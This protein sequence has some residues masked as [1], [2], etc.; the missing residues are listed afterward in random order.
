MSRKSY[1]NTRVI[2]I[3]VV[4]LALA[5]AFYRIGLPFAQHES[6][7]TNS[8]ANLNDELIYRWDNAK[9]SNYNAKFEM[10]MESRDFNTIADSLGFLSEY[11]EKYRGSILSKYEFMI[12]VP[13]SETKE[14]NSRVRSLAN[15]IK[16]SNDYSTALNIG[17]IEAYN[18]SLVTLQAK[19]KSLEQLR[20]ENPNIKGYTQDIEETDRAIGRINSMK[21]SL[22]NSDY[23]LY[24]IA[25]SEQV[26]K[27]INSTQYVKSL[28]TQ[29]II[30]L[31]ALA[32]GVPLL[33]LGSKLLFKVLG[34]VGAST[35]QLYGTYYNKSSKYGN[36]SGYGYNYGRKRQV[37]RVYK[38]K[39][40]GNSKGDDSKSPDKS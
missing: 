2:I 36:Y 20:R 6:R 33:M 1:R 15:L 14:F 34:I 10:V 12:R 26:N 35:N 40:N 3:F 11:V 31:G 30:A 29:F 9:K 5:W 18:D 32:L 17:S 27:G 19:R 22:Q 25:F 13:V 24:L 16:F 39:N 37:K 21:H 28:L 8:T 38:D 4:L 7:G 23:D